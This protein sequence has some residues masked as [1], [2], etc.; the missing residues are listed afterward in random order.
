MIL[1]VFSGLHDSMILA[2]IPQFRG[3]DSGVEMRMGREF[4]K[5]RINPKSTVE[6]CNPSPPGPPFQS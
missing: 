1:E 4:S 3:K 6:A 5:Y 2:S